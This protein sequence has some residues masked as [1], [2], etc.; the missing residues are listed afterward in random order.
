MYL[1][2]YDTFLNNK[3]FNKLLI[4]IETRLN[5]L[6]IKG[7]F[8]RISL[9]K[10]IDETI[11]EAVRSDIKTVVAV[12]DD[13]T[14]S[15][16][17]NFSMNHDITVGFIPVVKNTK[18]SSILG[19]PYGVKAC[20][21]LAQRIIRKIDIGKI[22]NQYFLNNAEVEDENIVIKFNG[23]NV[24]PINGNTVNFCNL[25]LINNDYC[26]PS[27]GM[28]EVII[29]PHKKSGF[30]S[31]KGEVKKSIFPFTKIKV[32][33]ADSPVAIKVDN[34]NIIKT[35]AEIKIIPNKLKIITSSQRKFE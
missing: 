18:I 28:L 9:L 2:I 1:Y 17:I 31:Q 29:T 3:K 34:Q 4:E 23:F 16:V 15:K 24:T 27:D 21:V 10:N 14:L 32:S 20:D 30:F 5:D 22:N 25:G 26:N 11:K 7:R 19:I 8:S 12:G 33:S 6:G 13:T 35:P